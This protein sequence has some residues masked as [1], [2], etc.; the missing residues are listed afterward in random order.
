MKSRT[1]IFILISKVYFCLPILGLSNESYDF[2]GDTVEINKSISEGRSIFDQNPDLAFEYWNKA[3]KAITKILYKQ[4]LL[5]QDLDKNL[6]TKLALIYTDQGRYF[7]NKGN[8]KEAL[9]LSFKSLTILQKADD[10]F[11]MA[12]N[13]NNMGVIYQTNLNDDST[14]IIMIGKAIELLE[15]NNEKKNTLTMYA[16]LGYIYERRKN[17]TLAFKNLYKSLSYIPFSTDTSG[18]SYCYFR[19]GTIHLNINNLDSA[20]YYL[21]K[22]LVL[23]VQSKNIRGCSVCNYSLAK[24]ALKQNRINDA[25]NY[26][27]T[28]LNQA[29][30]INFPSDVLNAHEMLANVYEIKGN[31]KESSINRKR[32]S[33]LKDSIA[34]IEFK[35][36]LLKNQ[37]SFEYKLKKLADSLNYVN[38]NK[39]R[40]IIIANQ[41]EVI[42][43]NSLLKVVYIVIF[44]LT[45]FIVFLFYRRLIYKKRKNELELQLRI[46]ET[47]QVLKRALMNPHFL[48]NSLNSIQ[49]LIIRNE[50]KI[51]RNYI[52]KISKL[53]RLILEQS[54]KQ[55]ITI[56]E[57]IRTIELYFEMEQLRFKDKFEFEISVDEKIQRNNIEIPAL[58]IQPFVENSIVHGIQNIADKVGLI[59]IN[60]SL[61]EKYLLCEVIDNGV[62]FHFKD[63]NEET[64]IRSK[65]F[66]IKSVKERL[67]NLNSNQNFE[68]AV[69]VYERKDNDGNVLGTTASLR[70]PYNKITHQL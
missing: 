58:I 41:N 59:K 67:N 25:E 2:V 26:A 32:Y 57:E 70:I 28:S 18:I 61:N 29:K 24:L 22:S 49:N 23:R 63:K 38:K 37:Y 65:S 14:A 36:Q 7:R 40:E 43:V 21:N 69:M 50:N 12:L 4:R 52:V 34:N 46:I 55:F 6:L 66:G 16:N 51:A 10:Y 64:I 19:L 60:L 8:P 31:W 48:F 54:E 3:E 13:Y 42:K 27:L 9:N 68:E 45:I 35:D 15:Q 47:E 56:D 1:I 17:T 44:I 30:S 53:M 11:T 39:E 62:G 33:N 20:N 5:G